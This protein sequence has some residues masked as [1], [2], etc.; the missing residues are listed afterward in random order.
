MA[1]VHFVKK[2]AKDNPA[3]GIKKGESYYWW[4][5]YKRPKQFSKT[6][7]KPSQLT[8]S[9]YR[10]Q[11]M[12]AIEALEAW[13]GVWAESDRDDLV[14][15]LEGIR[16]TQQDRYDNMPEGLQQGDTG[17]LLEE[18]INALEEWISELENLSFEGLEELQEGDETPL[19]QALAAVPS[20]D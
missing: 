6:R 11:V 1:K 2:A 9:E 5:L 10:Q 18:R 14:A 17:V 15:E 13:E 7:P 3:A 20:V 19:D 8:G 12:E 16:D 4:Q